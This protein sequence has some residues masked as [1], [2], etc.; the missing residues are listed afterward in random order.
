MSDWM[1]DQ[2]VQDEYEE[3]CGKTSPGCL[4]QWAIDRLR[5]QADEIKQLREE[6]DAWQ[7]L[8]GT[9]WYKRAMK[10]EAIAARLPLDLQGDPILPNTTRYCIHPFDGRI[11]EVE[12]KLDLDFTWSNNDVMGQPVKPWNKCQRHIRESFKTYEAAEKGGE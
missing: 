8:D 2:D 11:C 10:A 3:A 5:D 7:S 4:S 9:N 12:V 1:C 6:M